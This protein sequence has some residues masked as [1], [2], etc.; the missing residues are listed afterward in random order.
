MHGHCRRP[1]L[2]GLALLWTLAAAQGAAAQ[3]AAPPTASEL[4]QPGLRRTAPKRISAKRIEQQRPQVASASDRDRATGTGSAAGAGT[5]PGASSARGVAKQQGAAAKPATPAP[6]PP[7][8]LDFGNGLT[9]LLNYTSESAYNPIGGIRQG[10]RYTQQIFF[11]IDAD[12]ERLAGVDGGSLHTIV[13]DRRGRS[14]TNDLIGNS[15]SVQEIYGGGQNIRLTYL[16]YEQKLFD[17]RLELEV[18]RLPGQTAFLGSPLY[19]NFQNNSVCGSPSAVFADTNFTYF[20][21]PTWAGTLKAK[22]NDK[23]FFNIGAYE[24]DP[25]TLRDDDN[26]IDFF[27]PTATGYNIPFELGY[28][29]TFANDRLPRNY[30]VGAIIDRSSYSDPVLDIAGGRT[31]FSGLAPL[32]R[33]GRTAAYQRFDQMVWRPDP[34][35][36]RGL[37]L[38]GLALEGTGG[39]QPQDFQI[40]F[41]AVDTGLFESRPY[42][43][44]DFTVS[45]QKFSDLGIADV[46]A[47]R[48]AQG[49]S[50]A[51]VADN[52]IFL[53]LNYGL[54]VTPAVRLTPNLQYIVNPDQN[55]FPFR[56]K[57]IPDVLVAGAKL[58]IDLFT[59]A[60]LAKGPGSL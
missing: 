60:G 42:D 37:T 21:A 25:R 12:L 9:L 10:A 22:L 15:V 48:V 7:C 2:A 16:S 4:D 34:D 33:F 8:T 47:A 5:A 24:V 30:G 58:S 59:L 17:D 26:G 19:C 52:E 55:R 53:E 13:T 18:G 1:L 31:L 32:S 45:V 36:Q 50:S 6:L 49:L 44:I 14:L 27:S 35:A 46:R 57:P 43:S 56:T 40:E 3:D 11:G 28:S 20:P 23:L 29:T 54:Q 51:N 41:G 39:R 38:F